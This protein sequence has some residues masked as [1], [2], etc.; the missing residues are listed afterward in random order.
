[1]RKKAKPYLMILPSISIVVLIFIVGLFFATIKSLGYFP[2]IGFNEVTLDYYR[3]IFTDKQFLSS[4]FFSLRVAF[5]SSFA[6]VVIG[7]F[8]AIIYFDN[9]VK[10][11][12][13]LL[14]IDFPIST[15]HIIIGFF[16]V[17]MLSQA[18]V[19]SR[20]LYMVGLINDSS[21]FPLLVY[22]KGGMGIII[23][24]IIKGAPFIL[25][26]TLSVLHK[27]NMKYLSIAMNL[28][29]SYRQALFSI[30][31]PIVTPTIVSGFIILFSFSFAA[32][33]LP[34]LIGPSL[35]KSLAELSMIH[36]YSIDFVGKIYSSAVNVVI[37]MISLLFAFIYVKSNKFLSKVLGGYY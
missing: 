23:A 25:M 11:S 22:D 13:K 27:I 19:L 5:I 34:A 4:F 33:E 14:T 28:G 37:T 21:E 31:L 15:P 3:D 17:S 36:Y 35:P 30:I 6:S 18:G 26:L 8:F 10:N 16:V 9:K 29:A 12:V 24:Y 20:L 1:M 32:Y 2:A 7:L